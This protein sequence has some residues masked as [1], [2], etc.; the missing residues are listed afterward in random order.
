MRKKVI[1]V[2]SVAVFVLGLVT[3]VL[4]QKDKFQKENPYLQVELEDQA[5]RTE[6]IQTDYGTLIRYKENAPPKVSADSTDWGLYSLDLSNSRY[7]DLDQINTSNVKSLSVAWVS[8]QATLATT[9]SIARTTLLSAHPRLL[10]GSCTRRI[11]RVT[12]S[13]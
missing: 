1:A 5:L 9:C 8:Q 11:I 4:A 7:A 2:L 12:S 13:R 10:M 3:P 6:T